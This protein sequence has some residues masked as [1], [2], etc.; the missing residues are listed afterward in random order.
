V[1]A[2]IQSLR[3]DVTQASAKDFELLKLLG[4]GAYGKVVLAKKKDLGNLYAMKITD[5]ESIIEEGEMEALLSEKKVLQNDCPFLVHLHYSFQTQKHFYL[6]MDYIAGGNLASHLKREDHFDEKKAQFITAE[7]VIAL[8]YLHSRG[9]IYRDLRPDNILLD[10]DGH[11]CLT[12]FGMSKIVSTKVTDTIK[13]Q[14]FRGIPEYIAPEILEGQE[15]TQ[16]VEWWSLGVVVYE[17]LLGFTPFEFEDQDLGKL[18]R[19][20]L[21]TRI[22]YPIELVSH[23]ARSLLEGFLQRNPKQRLDEID[24]IKHHPFFNGIDWEKL[25]VKNIISP[26]KIELKSADDTSYFDWKYT[27]QQLNEEFSSV[28]DEVKL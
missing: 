27:S 5:K 9:V 18:I 19:A 24:E 2:R 10:V 25:S 16:S 7:V 14:T 28:D 3:E 23:N 13:M 1:L 6:V 11:V 26:F 12:D 21:N 17:M 8:D 22:L 4:E 20:I 15:Y